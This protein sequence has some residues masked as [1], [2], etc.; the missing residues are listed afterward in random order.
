[1]LAR[2]DSIQRPRPDSRCCRCAPPC[3]SCAV[4]SSRRW[5]ARCRL[6]STV[7]VSVGRCCATATCS[8]TW[9]MSGA[10][11]TVLVL[12]SVLAAAMSPIESST[13][14]ASCRAEL[15]RSR[16]ARSTAAS[17]PAACASAASAAC[18]AS[19]ALEP[20]PASTAV[21]PAASDWSMLGSCRSAPAMFSRTG[22]MEAPACR[23]SSRSR[24]CFALAMRPSSCWRDCASDSSTCG[25]VR[26]R[27]RSCSNEVAWLASSVPAPCAICRMRLDHSCRS[28][29]VSGNA[30]SSCCCSANASVRPPFALSSASRYGRT[31]SSPNCAFA[32]ASSCSL[33]CTVSSSCTSAMSARCLSSSRL[34]CCC[35][36]AAFSPLRLRPARTP[37]VTSQAP[38]P[39]TAAPPTSSTIGH[40]STL[41]SVPP[42]PSSGA[43]AASA[44]AVLKP[45]AAPG[46]SPLLS[47]GRSE[48]CAIWLTS[49]SVSGK[50]CG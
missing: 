11:S 20:S 8:S 42:A 32:K 45:V 40:T 30:S 31:A 14:S 44:T 37:R 29:S 9:R 46:T 50:P 41:T 18:T 35:W 24:I 21:R 10:R 23:S 3:R 36:I 27:S 33:C 13:S 43:A 7:S 6:L 49:A 5:L 28:W 47:P 19:A 4:A 38:P 1:M 48:S 39:T 26:S 16:S 2:A 25:A 34:S 22:S 12:R 15:S 17:R